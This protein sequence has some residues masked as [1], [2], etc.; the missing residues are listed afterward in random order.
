MQRRDYAAQAA[1]GLGTLLGGNPSDAG[2]EYLDKI[3]GMMKGY[4]DPYINA[5]KEVLP[6]LQNQY[7]QLVNDPSS[8]MKQFGAGF[9][10]D[11]GYQWNLGE[12]LRGSNQA[13][14]AGGMAGSP[15][16]QQ[17]SGQI[18]SNMANNTY[19]QYLQNTMGLYGQGLQGQQSLYDTSFKGAKGLSEDLAQALMSQAKM[20][21]EGQ[22]S[23]NQGLGGLL[24][25][26][27]GLMML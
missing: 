4:M 22:A 21:Y 1:G 9:Q 20:A 5:G 11:P 24:S 23:D 18:A 12:A 25:G 3:S 6:S 27:A 15:M 19:Q 10:E 8:K 17:Q 26:A 14:A 16:A 2:M 7:G 13:A